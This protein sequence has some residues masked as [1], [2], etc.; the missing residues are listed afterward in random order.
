MII[1][2]G[3]FGYHRTVTPVT[4]LAKNIV[5]VIEVTFFIWYD[6]FL[7]FNSVLLKDLQISSG[8]TDPDKTP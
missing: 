3:P 1:H 6:I 2:K 7:K 5:E 4:N 8:S